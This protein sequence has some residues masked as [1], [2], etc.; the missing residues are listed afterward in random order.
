MIKKV[1][2]IGA[3]SHIAKGLI[4]NYSQKN[5]AEIFLFSRNPEQ[6]KSFLE[7]IP[8]FPF[9]NHS[10][11]DFGKHHYDVIINCI[12]AGTPER[13]RDSGTSV[14]LITRIY[15]EMIIRYL[16]NNPDTVYIYFSSGV[17]LDPAL[18][19]YSI[20]AVPYELDIKTIAKT[21][22]Y[23][24]TKLC[25]EKNHRLFPDFKIVDIRIFAYF[26]RFIDLSSGFLITSVLSAVLDKKMLFTNSGNI[27]RDYLH[28]AD[29]FTLIE[30]CVAH[31]PGNSALEAFSRS[32]VCKFDLLKR[33]QQDYN[34]HYEILDNITISNPTGEKEVFVP[35]DFSAENIGYSPAY[36]S[37]EGVMEE[38][39][40]FMNNPRLNPSLW[41]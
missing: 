10:L 23:A 40:E 12:G 17:A 13:V 18:E 19:K 3:T 6:V 35:R 30:C 21:D 31:F 41:H 29:L 14:F 15:D 22:V 32:P 26:S 34:L 9:K 2:I 20:P 39:K 37:L 11:K 28:P 7:N 27:V 16:V 25:A 1:A 8:V 36:T 5:N 24:V 33:F 4:Y 38:T